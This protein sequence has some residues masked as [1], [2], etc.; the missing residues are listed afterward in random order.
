VF[1]RAL[2]KS[3]DDRYRSCGEFSGALREAA[4]IGRYDAPPPAGHPATQLAWAAP[5]CARAGCR[6]V[7]AVARDAVVASRQAIP[8]RLALRQALS[9]AP[10]T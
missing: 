9:A 6:G 7:R 10:V 8:D 3:P 2:A 1:A 5:A 4:G